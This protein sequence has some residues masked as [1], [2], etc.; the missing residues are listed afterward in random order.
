M[1]DFERLVAGATPEPRS[2]F[3]ERAMTLPLVRV[4]GHRENI[5]QPS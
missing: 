3:L 1:E 4:L 2:T 5:Q